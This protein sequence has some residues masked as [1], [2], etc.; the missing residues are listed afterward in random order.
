MERKEVKHE[1]RN[2]RI[3]KHV[4][5]RGIEGEYNI[6]LSIENIGEKIKNFIIIEIIPSSSSI[7]KFTCSKAESHEIV[8]V[9]DMSELFIK[10]FELNSNSSVVI[11]YNLTGSSGYPKTSPIVNILDQD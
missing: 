10:V 2:F 8:R 11:N 3:S 4:E 1:K 6:E 9:F 7:T 5:H